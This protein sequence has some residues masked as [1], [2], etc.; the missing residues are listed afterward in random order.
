MR[1]RL[2][3][4]VTAARDAGALPPDTDPA[5]A[6]R[7]GVALVLGIRE[8]LGR[9]GGPEVARLHDFILGG[10]GFSEDRA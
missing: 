9:S 4:L 2:L 10:L 8:E 5:L 3:T 6:T 7:F 1:E